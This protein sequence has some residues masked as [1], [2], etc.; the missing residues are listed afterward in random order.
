MQLFIIDAW[1]TSKKAFWVCMIFILG[2]LLCSIAS[3][4]V[5]PFFLWGHYS[6]AHSP[7]PF[8]SRI[9][10]KVNGKLLNL[11]AL[12]RPTREM[13]V[14]PV[15]HFLYLG[16]NNYE[17]ASKQITQNRFSNVLSD[18][19]QEYFYN[20]LSNNPKDKVSFMQWLSRYLYAVTHLEIKTLEIGTYNIVFDAQKQ[21][22]SKNYQPMASIVLQ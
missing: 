17:N 8:Y 15:A 20:C 16:E 2:N 6:E 18:T 12:P 3:V 7:Q 19:Q 1:N 13:I 22:K 9:Y 10:A 21:A 5:T 14:L 11:N 4:E